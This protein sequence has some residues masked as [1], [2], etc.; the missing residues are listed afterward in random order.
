M[1]RVPT[2]NAI[3]RF[4]ISFPVCQSAGEAIDEYLY[5][6]NVE[7]E[8]KTPSEDLIRLLED[9]SIVDEEALEVNAVI[10]LLI[11]YLL[12]RFRTNCINAL[13]FFIL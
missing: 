6:K 2:S 7:Y 9:I 1:V 13:S 5:F 10:D 11:K 12:C 3:E 8:I 4:F